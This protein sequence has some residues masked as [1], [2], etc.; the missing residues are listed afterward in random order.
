MLDIIKNSLNE[1]M[2][3]EEKI[4]LTREQLQIFILKI[5]F[6]IGGFKNLAFVG[7]T[8]GTALRIIFGLRRF[9]ED[10][11]FSLIQKRKGAIILISSRGPCRVNF[12][13]MAL[14]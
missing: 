7:G 5:L 9:S 2:S 6:D 8:G 3:R 12:K 10:L 4:H 14:M 13:N 1:R 11:D